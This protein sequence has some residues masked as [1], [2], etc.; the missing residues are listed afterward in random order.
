MSQVSGLSLLTAFIA[1]G[2]GILSFVSPCVLPLVPLYVGYLGGS[3]FSAEGVGVSRRAIVTNATF[4]VLGFSLVFV[5][6]G[7]TLGTLFQSLLPAFRQAGGVVLIV[8]GLSMMGLFQLPLLTRRF[9]ALSFER[10]RPG[11]GA[12]MVVGM[13]FAA[14]WTPCI[15]PL[16]ASILLLAGSSANWTQGTGLLALYSLGLGVPFVLLAAGMG[17]MTP[18]I[19]GLKAHLRSVEIVSGCFLVLVG[20][21]VASNWL[22][23]FTALLNSTPLAK[24]LA[25]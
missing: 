13:V 1:F 9:S 21:L 15:G 11:K 3:A 5:A 10:Y 8:F 25:P 6:I 20:M 4:F 23:R 22:L 17:W 19:R 16:L 7:A 14:G 2:G 12:S 24:A 18:L